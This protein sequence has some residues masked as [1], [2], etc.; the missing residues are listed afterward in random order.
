M[1]K[2]DIACVQE[3]HNIATAIYEEGGY[4]IICTP[5]QAT[6]MLEMNQSTDKKNITKGTGGGALIYNNKLE[7]K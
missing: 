3:T 6:G 1:Q 2:I 5:S 7:K 4:K